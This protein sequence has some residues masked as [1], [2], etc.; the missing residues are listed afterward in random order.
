MM[1]LLYAA[2]VLIS[3][4]Y[5]KDILFT[6]DS[7]KY[8]AYLNSLSRLTDIVYVPVLAAFFLEVV[9]PGKVTNRQLATAI[10]IQF[11][12]VPAF[13]VW[14]S[15]IVECAAAFVAYSISA[16]TVIGLT[17]FAAR[18]RRLMYDNYSYTENID[19]QWVLFSCYAY[20]GT[21]V[22]YSL[23][24]RE[25]TWISEIIFNLTGVIL[26]SVIF[27]FARRHR[28]LKMFLAR[29]DKA[30]EGDAPTEPVDSLCHQ[31]NPEEEC[32]KD[33]NPDNHT[34]AQNGIIRQ[35]RDRI[36]ALRLQ[37]LMEE[38]K[39]YLLPKLSI[40]DLSV[41]IGTNK[42]YL[43]DYLNNSLNTTFHEYVNRFR[44]EEACTMMDAMTKP[45]KRTMADI[46]MKCGFNSISSFNRHFRK[47]K[48]VSPRDY[49]LER[50]RETE[51]SQE[52]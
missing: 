52:A 15:Q 28:V 9:R 21:H 13:I 11:S 50:L 3:I 38:Q 25:S 35:E 30:R 7:L 29:K 42:T 20:F 51:V 1:R 12:F 23:S 27:V 22:L 32:A 44:I 16:A 19:V 2:S 14:P 49:M 37:Q 40:V 47:V 46:S 8:S 5:A 33:D 36:I 43:S 4:G 10:A 45:H 17:I 41:K 39:L 6:F 24:F 26:W 31:G 34:D 18:Y 48:G